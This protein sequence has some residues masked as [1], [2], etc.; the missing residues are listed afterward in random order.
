MKDG[1][2][3]TGDWMVYITTRDGH[4]MNLQVKAGQH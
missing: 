4:V 3:V 2:G 1:S